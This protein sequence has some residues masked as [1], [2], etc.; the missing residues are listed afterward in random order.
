MDVFWK[1]Q[2][3]MFRASASDADSGMRSK[4]DIKYENVVE[5]RHEMA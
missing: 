3:Q 2:S 1:E 4:D 5:K